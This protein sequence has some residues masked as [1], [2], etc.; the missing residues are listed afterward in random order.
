MLKGK[1]GIFYPDDKS[2][3]EANTF[4]RLVICNEEQAEQKKRNNKNN[5]FV[6]GKDG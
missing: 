3:K 2:V 1:V 5:K 6:K 4:G